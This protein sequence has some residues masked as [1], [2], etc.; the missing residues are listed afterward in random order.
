M[1]ERGFIFSD[2]P[3]PEA[4]LYLRNKGLRPSFDWQ[5]VWAQEHAH[6]FT[7]AKATQLEVLDTIRKAVDRALAT[8]QTYEDFA[9]QLA[10]RLQGFGWWG[11]QIVTDPLT[12]EEVLAQLGSPQRL[13]LIYDA[14]IRSAH[15]AGQWE[16]AQRTKAV[17][18]FFIYIETVSREPREEHLAQVGTIAHVDDPYWDTWFPPNGY[19]C[20]CGVRQITK[21][22]AEKRGWTPKSKPPPWETRPFVNKRTGIVDEVPVGIDPGWHFNPAKA[23]F[24]TLDQLLSGKLDDAAPEL[25]EIALKDMTSNWLFR[26]FASSDFYDIAAPEKTPNIAAAVGHVSKELRAVTGQQSGVVWLTPEKPFVNGKPSLAMWAKLPGLIDAGTVVQSSADARYL[27]FYQR[28]DGKMYRA[29]VAVRDVTPQ[30]VRIKGGRLELQ[31]FREVEDDIA[32]HELMIA[33]G[34]KRVLRRAI[35]VPEKP[36]AKAPPKPKPPPLPKVHPASLKLPADGLAG[37]DMSLAEDRAVQVATPRRAKEALSYYAGPGYKDINRALRSK[38]PLGNPAPDEAV[39]FGKPGVSVQL[40][41]E[42]LNSSLPLPADTVLYRSIALTPAELQKHKIGAQITELGYVST[43][44]WKRR[45]ETWRMTDLER[46]EQVVYVINA[47]GSKG[48][49]LYHLDEVAISREGEVLLPRGTSYV[50]TKIEEGVGPPT[51]ERGEMRRRKYTRVY[52]NVVEKKP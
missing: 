46:S 25:R 7:V 35:E 19:N 30:G 13:R 51:A 2:Q 37:A 42:A 5:D 27:I 6:A 10:P 38:Q 15:A 47:G 45:A 4:L 34:E 3:S 9:K 22:E 14:N 18:P 1:P 39:F 40:I 8:G 31:Y 49:P 41:D 52:V 23:R 43:S 16:R 29:E 28:I 48:L 44:R 33:E 11:R 50:V 21:S 24:S 20:K 32:R 36:K 17:L 12:G 26:R